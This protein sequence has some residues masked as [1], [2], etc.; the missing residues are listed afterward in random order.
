VQ[1]ELGCELLAGFGAVFKS[2]GDAKLCD[3]DD[4]L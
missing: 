3:G 2:V 1:L 4:G